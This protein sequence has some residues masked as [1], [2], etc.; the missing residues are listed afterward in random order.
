MGKRQFNMHLFRV[1]IVGIC[2]MDLNCNIFKLHDGS[3]LQE[4]LV[5]I[6]CVHYNVQACWS[7]KIHYVN[8]PMSGFTRRIS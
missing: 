3:T 6:S 2:V 5:Y 8:I 4:C 7:T 1:Y